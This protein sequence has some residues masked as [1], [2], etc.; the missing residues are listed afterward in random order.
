LGDGFYNKRLKESSQARKR[1]LALDL[2]LFTK[3]RHSREIGEANTTVGLLW[4]RWVRV[5][6]RLRGRIMVGVLRLG[7]GMGMGMGMRVPMHMRMHF[8]V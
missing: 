8:D 1:T 6:V 5:L 3:A 4:M 7:M 2:S